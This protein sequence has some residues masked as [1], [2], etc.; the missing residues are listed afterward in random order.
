LN[1]SQTPASSTAD[2]TLSVGSAVSALP[3]QGSSKSQD[4]L[5]GSVSNN[6]ISSG[7]NGLSDCQR[8]TCNENHTNPEV[9]HCNDIVS[10]Q[11]VACQNASQYSELTLPSFTDSSKQVAVH[12]IRELDEY[13]ELKETPQNLRLPLT[14]TAIT[15]P[16]AKNWLSTVYSQLKS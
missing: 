16:F 11:S 7:V 8:S 4:I 10:A 3:N 15:E 12:F 13:F 14:F 6:C 9:T 2:A 1:G 5:A